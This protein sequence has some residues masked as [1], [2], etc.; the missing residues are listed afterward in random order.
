M[1]KE[2]INKFLEDC[3]SQLEEQEA[4]LDSD[5]GLFLEFVSNKLDELTDE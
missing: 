1:N 4:W 3:Y 5:A 2:Q